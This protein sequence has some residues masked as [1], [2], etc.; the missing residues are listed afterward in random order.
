VARY[1]HSQIFGFPFVP[2]LLCAFALK[3]SHGTGPHGADREMRTVEAGSFV[4]FAA[5]RIGRRTSSP[6]QLGQTK[7]SFFDAHSKQKVHSNV[8]M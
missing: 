4:S 2:L 7:P 3:F 6:L 8:Q 1:V 5:G